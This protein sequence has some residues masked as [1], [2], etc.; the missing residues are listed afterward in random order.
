MKNRVRDLEA[1]LQEEKKQNRYLMD[2][3]ENMKQKIDASTK[4]LETL[5]LTNLE[6]V[7]KVSELEL[8]LEHR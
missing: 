6:L 8:R 5:E 1:S 3:I 2:E 7:Q 4:Q